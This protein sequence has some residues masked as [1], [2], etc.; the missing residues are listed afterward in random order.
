[1]E[2]DKFFLMEQEDLYFESIFIKYKWYRKIYGGTWRLIGIKNLYSIN[3]YPIW[4]KLPMISWSSKTIYETEEYPI[5]GVDTRV[6][7][8]KQLIKQ[9]WK[10]K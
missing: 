3:L 5:T 8:F 4:T 6:K 1:M 10:K 7:F 2:E 9:I